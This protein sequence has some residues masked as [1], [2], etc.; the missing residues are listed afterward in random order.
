MLH[1]TRQNAANLVIVCNTDV[2]I[3]RS[4]KTFRLCSRRTF[5]AN[6]LMLLSVLERFFYAAVR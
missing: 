6:T 3:E 5:L 4:Y 2:R 1:D